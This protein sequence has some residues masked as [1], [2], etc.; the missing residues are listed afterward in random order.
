MGDNA[1]VIRLLPGGLSRSRK[2]VV[3]DLDDTLYLEHEYVLSGFRHIAGLVAPDARQSPESI[4]AFL[5]A[6]TTKREHRGHNLDLLLGEYPGLRSAWSASRLIEEYRR[7]NPKISLFPGVPSMLS[8]L[9]D[10]GAYLAV[11]TDGAS[12]SQHRKAEALQ[13]AEQ[14]NL[15]IVTDDHGIEYRKPHPYAYRRVSKAS[16]CDHAE[17]VYVGDNPAKDF[18]APR[19]LGWDTIRIRF[20]N[21]LHAQAEPLAPEAAP[22]VECGDIT[23][24]SALLISW[25]S[26]SHSSRE[27]TS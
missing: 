3:F 9:R 11:I 19:V 6:S 17:C 26:Q 22:R 10:A 25:L 1:A 18:F 13:L 14:V 23:Q 7:H 16:G 12:Q 27:A 24:L 20:P 4:F 15:V 8:D 5:Q 2:A 21:Q